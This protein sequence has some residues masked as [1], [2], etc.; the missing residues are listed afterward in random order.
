MTIMTLF[1]VKQTNQLTT[2]KNEA[3]LDTTQKDM[4]ACGSR[5]LDFV[6]SI[7]RQIPSIIVFDATMRVF[8]F[9]SIV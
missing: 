5:G 3:D 9:Y 6:L 2:R 4:R 8:D 7:L 1:V